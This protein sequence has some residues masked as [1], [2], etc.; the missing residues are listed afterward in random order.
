MLVGMAIDFGVHLVTRY[1]EELRHG[2]TEAQAMEKPS[3]SPARVFSRV[4]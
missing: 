3:Y 2:K 1:E 4:P